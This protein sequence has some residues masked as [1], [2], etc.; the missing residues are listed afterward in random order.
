MKRIGMVRELMFYHSREPCEIQNALASYR[1]RTTAWVLHVDPF[2]RKVFG[3]EMPLFPKGHIRVGE[4]DVE[5]VSRHVIWASTDNAFARA[6]PIEPGSVKT[7]PICE[8]LE[9]GYYIGC[10]HLVEKG[11]SERAAREPGFYLNETFFSGHV[12]VVTGREIVDVRGGPGRKKTTLD[13]HVDLRHDDMVVEGGDL[14][15]KIEWISV[16][17]VK[18][19]RRKVQENLRDL[20]ILATRSRS[21]NVTLL[22]DE[23]TMSDRVE[24]AATCWNCQAAR[25]ALKKCSVCKAA[26]YCDA[27]CQ[28][29]HWRSHKRTCS[30]PS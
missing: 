19:V 27:A 24:A 30:L 1:D 4:E 5:E 14:L 10:T 16:A 15:A 26:Y 22:I 17:Q 9:T 2:E 3:I 21:N 29:A 25:S 20:E 6:W 8:D 7:V 23:C 18:A 11:G 28:K 12:M 13:M